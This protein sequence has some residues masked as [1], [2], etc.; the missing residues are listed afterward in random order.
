MPRYNGTA[1]P[2]YDAEKFGLEKIVDF[3]L[4]EPC[5]SFDTYVV[6][7][8]E[9]DGF[10]YWARDSGCSCPA[11]FEDFAVNMEDDGTLSLPEL[12][13]GLER[14]TWGNFIEALRAIVDTVEDQYDWSRNYARREASVAVAELAKFEMYRGIKTD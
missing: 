3:E 2:Y 1:D 6:W 4:S 7:Y 11:P 9:D 8:R 5:Y 10:Y 12:E 13:R 14:L